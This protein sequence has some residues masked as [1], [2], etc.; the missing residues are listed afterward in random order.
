MIVESSFLFERK[1]P[2][3]PEGSNSAVGCVPILKTPIDEITLSSDVFAE[4]L[5]Q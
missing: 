5:K 2:L 3:K 1:N 4:L